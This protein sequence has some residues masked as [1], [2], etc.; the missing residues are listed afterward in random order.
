MAAVH[1]LSVG[2]GS[3]LLLSAALKLQSPA[4]FER[5]VRTA[6]LAGRAARGAAYAVILVEAV[7]AVLLVAGALPLV[8]LGA[9]ACLSLGFVVLQASTFLAGTRTTCGCFG[10]LDAAVA[11]GVHLVRALVLA[12]LALAALVALVAS[13]EAHT[14]LAVPGGLEVA[15]GGLSGT[16][17]VIGFALLGQVVFFQ[18]W[19]PRG[20][21]APA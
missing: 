12:A 13:K 20:S 4:E 19:R 2:V 17:F 14:L 9:A 11:P 15:V 1:V 18:R 21:R 10:P 16:S 3:I 7:V 8:A 5:Y 6:G